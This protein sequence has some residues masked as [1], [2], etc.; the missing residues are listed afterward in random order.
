MMKNKKTFVFFLLVAACSGIPMLMIGLKQTLDVR[1][2]YSHAEAMSWLTSLSE[3]QRADY[4][5]NEYLDLGYLLGYTGMFFLLA[6]PL[7][8]IPGILDLIETV[9]I[10]LHLNHM[11]E[12][13]TFL[14][15]ISG[16][17]WISG[18]MVGVLILMKFIGRRR[19]LE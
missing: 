4:L 7:G 9:P 17:K 13:P 8:L 3:S 6:G 19:K 1:L 10:I 15:T 12:L 11:M 18:V 5:L 14:G 2:F 16:V